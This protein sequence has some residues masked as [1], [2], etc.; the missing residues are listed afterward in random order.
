MADISY[1]QTKE[2]IKSIELN[3]NKGLIKQVKKEQNMLS[4]IIKNR[5]KPEID[6]LK[7]MISTKGIDAI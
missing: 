6:E 5:L 4:T 2:L 1:R 3:T 7:V